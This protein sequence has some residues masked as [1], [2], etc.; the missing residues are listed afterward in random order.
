MNDTY[1]TRE[2]LIKKLRYSESEA[3]W[4]EFVYF[5]R[6]FIYSIIKRMGLQE[7][8]CDDML[9][10]VL[11]KIW[12]KIPEFE[13][14]QRKG[15]FRSWISSTTRN[16][17][18]NFSKKQ[19]AMWDKELAVGMLSE[20]NFQ[21]PPYEQFIEEE[22][23]RNITTLAFKNVAK[24]VSEQS[25]EIFNCSVKGESVADIA[26]RLNLP[27]YKVYRYRKRVQHLLTAEIKNLKEY[28][29]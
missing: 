3:D 29:E 18:Y 12:K 5:Y 16:T 23:K 10:K 20:G 6:R 15:A 27:D 28:L 8:D 19:Q 4:E 11:L 9:Q 26:Q 24:N 22:W 21:S 17:V 14:N 2:T 25:M 7:S 13:P 1:L